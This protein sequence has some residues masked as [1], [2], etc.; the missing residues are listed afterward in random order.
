MNEDRER[1]RERDE[2]KIR[3]KMIKDGN[4]QRKNKTKKR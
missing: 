3:Q 1:T 2:T 4:R